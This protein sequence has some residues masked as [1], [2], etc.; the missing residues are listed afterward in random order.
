MSFWNQF[1]GNTKENERF[2]N[3]LANDI[4]NSPSIYI[5]SYFLDTD[6]DGEVEE[7]YREAALK[8]AA[9]LLHDDKTNSDDKDFLRKLI[10]EV[11]EN[12]DDSL[13]EEAKEV[14]MLRADDSALLEIA[15]NDDESTGVRVKAVEKMTDKDLLLDVAA[16]AKDEDVR[17][18]A[19]KRIKEL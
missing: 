4:L 13:Y 7:S 14:L 15:L 18:A 8:A 16:D 9:R 2:V 11:A 1:I 19:K 12:D 17:Q 6:M 5:V 10:N 3:A